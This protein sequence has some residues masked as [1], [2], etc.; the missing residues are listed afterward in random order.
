MR[1]FDKQAADRL[2]TFGEAAGDRFGQIAAEFGWMTTGVGSVFRLAPRVGD[3]DVRRHE[4]WWAA[5]RQG[6]LLSSSGVICASTVM[7]DDLLHEAATRL[8]AAFA[9]IAH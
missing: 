8:Q 2:R 4:L 1:A 5:Y 6:L 9:D 7:D 3:S